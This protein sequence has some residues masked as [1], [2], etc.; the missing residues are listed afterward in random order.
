MGDAGEEGLSAAA[1]DNGN[2]CDLVDEEAMTDAWVSTASCCSQ[3]LVVRCTSLLREGRGDERKVLVRAAASG[4]L[5]FRH[6]DLRERLERSQ[7]ISPVRFGLRRLRHD[8][9]YW[10]RRSAFGWTRGRR[11]R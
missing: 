8:V 4:Y 2:D 1:S 11:A 5:S 7:L 3:C 9:D 6:I 10:S